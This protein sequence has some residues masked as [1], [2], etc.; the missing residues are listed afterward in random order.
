M[1][2]L[3]KTFKKIEQAKELLKSQ[4]YYVDSL[5]SISDIK[6]KFKCTDEEAQYVLDKVFDNDALCNDIWETICTVGEHYELT[7]IKD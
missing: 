4:G 5:W 6:C 1:V 3:K 7:Y 2:K